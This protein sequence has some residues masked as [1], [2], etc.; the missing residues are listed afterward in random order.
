MMRKYENNP[1]FMRIVEK[2][3]SKTIQN[4]VERSG[5]CD[6]GK[7]VHKV[8]TSGNEANKTM[9]AEE[10]EVSEMI[11]PQDSNLVATPKVI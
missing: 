3:V 7:N 1:H 6:T 2:M 10:T 8:V 9:Q 4:G 11:V 5:N